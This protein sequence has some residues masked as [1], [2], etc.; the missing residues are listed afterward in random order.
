MSQP[1]RCFVKG[2][3]HRHLLILRRFTDS[4]FDLSNTF[5]ITL[6]GQDPINVVE[7]LHTNYSAFIGWMDVTKPQEQRSCDMKWASKLPRSSHM[8]PK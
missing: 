3:L 6:S 2:M 4:L 5:S 8:S 1:A 7:R